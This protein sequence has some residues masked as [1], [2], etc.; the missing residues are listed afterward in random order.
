V[1][2]ETT[3]SLDGFGRTIGTSNLVGVK[4]AVEYD[5]EGRKRYDSYPFSGAANSGTTFAF[6]ALDRVTR[7]TNADGSFAQYGYSAGIDVTITD[8]EGRVTTQ[9]WSAF[10]DPS[11]ARLMAVTDGEQHTFTYGY[12]GIGRL[13][14]VNQPAAPPV[15]G[16]TGG[17][18]L[19]QGRPSTGV[20]HHVLYLRCRGTAEREGTIRA[21]ISPSVRRQRST[22]RD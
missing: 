10:G 1:Q 7:I 22:Q 18:G 16:R 5:A 3:I 9:D 4:T 11:D 8:E 13:T 6:D 15:I 19:T 2:S 12:N 21:G 20:R 14:A 17:P